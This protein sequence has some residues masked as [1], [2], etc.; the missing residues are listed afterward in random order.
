MSSVG[1]DFGTE[2]E[3][4][5]AKQ[6]K[7]VIAYLRE[8]GDDEAADRL[9]QTGAGG[10]GLFLN[11]GEEVW[12]LTGMILGYIPPEAAAT[13]D[14]EIQNATTMAPD[15]EL[16]DT[17]IKISL[18][19]FWVQRYPG[20]GTHKILL[21]FA[22]KN[23]IET[24]PEELRFVLTTEA[25][26]RSS[27]AVNGTPIFLGASVGK[28][29]ISFEGKAINVSSGDDEELLS[30]LGSGPMKQGLSLLT[31]A[32]PALKPF[33]GIA[34]GVVSAVL[35]RSRNRQVY[36][37]KLGLDFASSQTSA[38]LREGSYVV[39]QGDQSLWSWSDYSW[40]ASAQQVVR[41]SDGQALEYNYLIFRVSRFEEA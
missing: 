15:A 12:G 8:I 19:R 3:S 14:G 18:D 35:K 11:W 9:Q 29:G 23:Q 5:G 25:R 28:N 41:R 31:T 37:F 36:Y 39:I 1:H 2:N 6:P 27:A 38:K 26:D 33:V 30:A 32:Q 34:Q 7:S 20:R 10:Q 13:D 4:L 17:R 16:K 22:G 21:E 40:N 24:D